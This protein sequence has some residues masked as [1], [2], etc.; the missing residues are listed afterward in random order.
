MALFAE[1][2]LVQLAL[3]AQVEVLD[4]LDDS[5]ADTNAAPLALDTHHELATNAA[6]AATANPVVVG[7]G[8]VDFVVEAVAPADAALQ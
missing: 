7:G 8:G 4:S 5:R 3:K 6:A 2:R 1:A